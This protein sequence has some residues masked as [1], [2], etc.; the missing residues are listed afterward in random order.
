VAV[1]PSTSNPNTALYWVSGNRQEG[2][3]PQAGSRR[4]LPAAAEARAP[5]PVSRG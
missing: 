3:D 2:F 4:M 5:K 1:R